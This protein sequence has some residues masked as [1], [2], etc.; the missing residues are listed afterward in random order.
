MFRLAPT[1]V[2]RPYAAPIDAMMAELR[3]RRV[4]PWAVAI[5]LGL[6]LWLVSFSWWAPGPFVPIVV[7]VVV[8][9]VIFG[10]RELQGAQAEQPVPPVNLTKGEPTSP[11]A[12]SPA[13]LIEGRKWW[14]EAREASRQ[15]RHRAL[16]VKVATLVGLT[17]TLVVLAIVDAA[18][19]IAVP[20]YFWVA[21]GFVAA[22]LL[23]GVVL[24]RTPWTITSLLPLTVAGLLAFGGSHASFHDGV[25]DRTWTPTTRPAAEYRLAF[26][27]GVLDLRRLPEQAT[28][29]TVRVT[30][31]AGQV[32]VLVPRNANVAVR[33]NVHIGQ[34]DVL[35]GS[36][37]VSGSGGIAVARDVPAPE[38][39]TGAR[40]TVVIHLADGRIQLVRS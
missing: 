27:Q 3:R 34:V 8:L 31:A 16:P 12:D 20:V 39:A 25:G 17:T 13:W 23:V 26:G 30:V 37:K 15:R 22:G 40:T 2:V 10:R 11:A 6:L 4:P 14:D 18:T 5:G 28:P 19:G 7:V 21:L 35:S 29:R 1:P 36:R 9:A 38:D 24:R 33:A 32:R